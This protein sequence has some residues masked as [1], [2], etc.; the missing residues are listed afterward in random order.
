M[1]RTVDDTRRLLREAAMAEFAAHGSDGTTVTRI[2]A[3]AGVNKERLYAYFGDKDALFD[4]VLTE[5]L[6]ELSRVVTPEGVDFGDMGEVA[7]RTFDYYGEHPELARLLLWEGLRGAP[8]V[9]ATARVEHYS[10][11]VAA[12]GR[13]QRDGS[14]DGG[15]DAGHLMFMIIGLAAWWFSVPQLATMLTGTEADDADERARR[16]AFVVEAARRLTRSPADVPAP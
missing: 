8:P 14:I 2:A 13:A 9:N 15:I 6:E 5:A 3:R 4:E 11:K 10:R 7:G 1:K 12:T 16:R